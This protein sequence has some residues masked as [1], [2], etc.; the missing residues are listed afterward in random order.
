MSAIPAWFDQVWLQHSQALVGNKLPHA[1]LSVGDAGLC[2]RQYI[3]SL[4]KLALCLS[5]EQGEPCGQ[6][7]SC[8]LFE[9]I[10]ERQGVHPDLLLIEGSGANNDIKIDQIRQIQDFMNQTVQISRRKVIVLDSL[11]QLNI[12][13][14]NALLKLLEEPNKENYFLLTA[15]N[16]SSLL[17]T[18][19]SRVQWFKVKT[20]NKEELTAYFADKNLSAHQINL[21]IQLLGYKP[22]LIERF[23]QLEESHQK[24]LERLLPS[25]AALTEGRAQVMD[26]LKSWLDLP[27]DLLSQVLYL[28]IRHLVESFFSPAFQENNDTPALQAM[29]TIRSS[30]S[31]EQVMTIQK[32]FGEIIDKLT[33]TNNLNEELLWINWL[34][35][36]LKK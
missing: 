10:F 1:L 6:C 20:P 12:F 22:R 31:I 21:G 9:S 34:N 23:Y 36:W 5:P 29:T 14:A 25:L 35:L 19:K 33:W 30:L 16:L 27:S 13:A 32:H 11:N 7:K 28:Q 26:V 15:E 24:S 8:H 2:K 4:A 17:P 18:I 3:E